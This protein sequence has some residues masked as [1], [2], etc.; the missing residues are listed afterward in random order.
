MSLDNPYE[1]LQSV[2][3]PASA[4]C[5]F[6][7][8]MARG[9]IE[10]IEPLQ[11]A[12]ENLDTDVGAAKLVTGGGLGDTYKFKT[13]DADGYP[14]YFTSKFAPAAGSGLNGSLTTTT[15]SPGIS[16]VAYYLNVTWAGA[17]S[18]SSV[19][20]AA[21][22]GSAA[23]HAHADH[24]H[25][26]VSSLSKTGEAAMTGAVTLTQGT[27]VTL[28]QTSGAISLANAGVISIYADATT[29]TGAVIFSAGT[30]MAITYSDHTVTFASTHY[31]E[32]VFYVGFSFVEDPVPDPPDWINGTP[33]AMHMASQPF[34]VPYTGTVVAAV[35]NWDDDSGHNAGNMSFQVENITTAGTG[36]SVAGVT[37]TGGQASA[38]GGT[39]AVTAG[40][41]VRIQA[42]GTT[43]GNTVAGGVTAWIIIRKS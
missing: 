41:T 6:S 28:T 22:A 9:I 19:G 40:N 43:V 16:N 26:G 18:I 11:R 13:N 14:A 29:L 38:T 17:G 2:E 12:V 32:H 5:I 36:L 25:A 8:E 39:L 30:G 42:K 20:S 15:V 23:S 33:Y 7:A 24:V 3:L 31:T 35:Y 34:L 37:A 1:G 10:Y 21:A 27:G 4:L